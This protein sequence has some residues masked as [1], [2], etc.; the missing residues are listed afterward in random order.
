MLHL[1]S[2]SKTPEISRGFFF[3]RSRR[4]SLSDPAEA[5]PEAREE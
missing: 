5:P 3:Y 1:T 2:K 4:L